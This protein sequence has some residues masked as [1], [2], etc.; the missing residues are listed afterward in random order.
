[1]TV[2]LQTGNQVDVT[3]SSDAELYAGFAGGG[4][5]VIRE[6]L[7]IKLED[8][9]TLSVGSGNVLQ[10]GR[11]IR[12]KGSTDFTIPSG[13][14]AQKRSHIAVIRTTITRDDE[15][16]ETLEKSEPLVLSG[17]PVMDGTPEDP[18]WIEGNLLAGDTIADFPLARVVTDGI[19]A[20]EP[21]PLYDVM[22]SA[23]EFQ[24]AEKERW[25]S[26]SQAVGKAPRIAGAHIDVSTDSN[27]YVTIPHGLGVKPT[28]VSVTP[29]QGV[30][31]T[32]SQIAQPIVAAYD[33]TNILVRVVRTDTHDWL[34]GNPVGLFWMAVA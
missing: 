15:T 23:A 34:R 22:A 5:Y 25:D 33:Q 27:G 9:N 14:Q 11:H 6:P 10:N 7:Q 19:N 8:S 2:E 30:N 12:L 32:V 31:A 20:L 13:I 18:A 28:T 4:S 26:I 16:M 17:E 1:M 24:A 21:E 3:S 29:A